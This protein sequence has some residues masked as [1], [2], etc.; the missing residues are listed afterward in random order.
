MTLAYDLYWSFRSP[1]SYLITPRLVALENAFDVKGRIRPAAR[2][3]G[4]P[5]TGEKP[6]RLPHRAAAGSVER[7]RLA[8]RPLDMRPPTHMCRSERRLRRKNVQI[9]A[10]TIAPPFSPC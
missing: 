9:P 5:D 2:E 4:P 7:R 10:K 1:Y 6:H 8:A 3:A